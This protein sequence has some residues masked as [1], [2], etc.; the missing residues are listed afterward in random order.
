MN[1]IRQ[2][3]YR[4]PMRSMNWSSSKSIHLYLSRLFRRQNIQIYRHRSKTLQYSYSQHSKNM[5]LWR[6]TRLYRRKLV[7][8]QNIRS[9][10]YMYRIPVYWNRKHSQH[11][12]LLNFFIVRNKFERYV[13]STNIKKVE[14]II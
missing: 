3:W 4:W 9:Y 14:K 13:I 11:N 10:K 12:Y 2:Y 7:H 8:L 6:H 5:S 1:R